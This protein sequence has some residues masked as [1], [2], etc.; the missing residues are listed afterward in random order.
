MAPSP[1]D[2]AAAAVRSHPLRTRILSALVLAPMALVVVWI[3]GWLMA[4]WVALA[5]VLMAREWSLLTARGRIGAPGVLLALGSVAAV[6][7]TAAGLAP[8]VSFAVLAGSGVVVYGL[9]RTGGVDAARW[10]AV[11]AVVVGVPCVALVWLRLQPADGRL[12]VFWLLAVVWATDIAA[13]AVGRS[14]GGPRLAPRVSPNKTWAGLAGGVIG[15]ALTGGTIAAAVGAGGVAAAVAGGVLALVAQ[16]GD[17]G[18]SLAKRRFGVKDT[19]ALI[20]G[21]GGLLDR[22]DGLLTTIPVV[23]LWLWLKGGNVLA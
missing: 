9:A 11:G 19:G 22:V 14:L 10:V 20:P 18:E 2:A 13:Y 1:A 4:L 8:A 17:L 5:A 16:A 15:A 7:A 21:H 3:G 23:A 6:A 12:M